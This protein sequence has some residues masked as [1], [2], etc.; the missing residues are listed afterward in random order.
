MAL[1]ITIQGIDEALSHFNYRNKPALKYRF[2]SLIRG[3]YENESAVETVQGIDA[4]EL[5][6]ILW[7]TGDNP[8]AVKNRRKN[9]KS[10]KSAIN[11]ELKKLY[12]EGKNPEGVT[13][14]PENTFVMS[15]EARNNAL[16]A[17]I[18]EPKEDG[19]ALV[20]QVKDVLK[21]LNEVLSNSP[22]FDDTGE[23]DGPGGL[24]EIKA[25]IRDL[26]EKAGLSGA[27]LI[28]ADAGIAHA[29]AVGEDQAGKT[30]GDGG[31]GGG[32]DQRG[33]GG[34]AGGDP[35]GAETGDMGAGEPGSG[36][37][38]EQAGQGIAPGEEME[39][40][41]GNAV[42]EFLEEID[43]EEDAE[44][45][46]EIDERLEEI[47]GDEVDELLEAVDD[48][49]GTED[50]GEGA[51]PDE[52]LEEI[53]GIEEIDLDEELEGVEELLEEVDETEDAEE[54]GEELD[55][56]DGDEV[57]EVLEEIA[58]GED[59]EEVEGD[60]V[61]ALLNETGETGAGDAEGESSD[62]GEMN[63]RTGDSRGHGLET[64]GAGPG[65]PGSGDSRERVGENLGAAEEGEEIDLD[66][67]LEEIE[68]DEVEEVL[69][70]IDETEIGETGGENVPE[71]SSGAGGS[72]TQGQPEEADGELE[73]IEGDEFEEFLEEVDE[74]EDA[75][76]A[77][78]ADGELEAVEEIED[79]EE[80]DPDEDL[81]EVDEDE[82]DD[83]LEEVDGEETGDEAGLVEGGPDVIHPGEPG[84]TI[85]A[86]QNARL[87]AEKFNEALAAMDKF[88]NQ[89]I[90]IPKDT[91]AIGSGISGKSRNI[92]RM[93]RLSSFY[94]GKSP[95]TNVLFEI[96]IEETGYKTTAETVGYG[97]V[98]NG[99]HFGKKTAETG[100]STTFSCNSALSVK[101]VKGACWYQP[102]G[103]GSTLYGKRNHPVVQ[104]SLEDAK[105]FAAWTGKRLPTEEEWEAAARTASGHPFPW[106]EEWID[107]SCNVEGS[108]I[109]D[110]TPVDKYG[111][112]ENS[113]GIVDTLGNVLEWTV[114]LS[115]EPDRGK[116]GS[117]LYV[118]K[119]GSFI[120]GNG[121]R[122]SDRTVLQAQY[123]SNIL[124]FR[125]VAY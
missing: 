86:E 103:P 72:E 25:L 84:G 91:F 108:L 67:E 73:E 74:T 71:G 87:L 16:E 8:A 47:D 28:R 98:F 112:F 78:E 97:T 54:I 123:H 56:V 6:K 32:T 48:A 104:V 89:Y 40:A 58:G 26:T 36:N 34:A 22:Y 51:N 107:N 18:R 59:A 82:I 45:A 23:E 64:G 53:E 63:G 15:D 99:R 61:E 76:E 33:P 94:M 13:I 83:L 10:V 90:L 50:K 77:E 57:E 121:I 31:L 24:R 66:E 42:E 93:V 79:V 17:F 125:C 19:T 37:S 46:E 92:E 105:A 60:E 52:E 29:E 27:E 7:D 20:G 96:F 124:G 4:D 49:E 114:T 95:V 70:E 39:E 88:Y 119:G 41:G 113:Y 100:T 69:E 35:G 21:V 106:G 43:D 11:N 117:G 102:F 115:K 116:D 75:G 65:G 118:T 80:I 62:R 109:G 101:V 12:E 111:D 44:N 120:S 122:L 5:I 9:F 110:T 2:I 38:W 30:E 14:G 3:H 81:E 85:D 55:E 68:G 1:A